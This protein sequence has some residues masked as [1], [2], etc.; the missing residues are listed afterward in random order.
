MNP[1][2]IFKRFF[3]SS[4]IRCVHYHGTEVAK[5]IP[6]H[7]VYKGTAFDL[8]D[9]AVDFVL[10]KISTEYI[11]RMGTGILDMIRRCVEADLPEPEFAVTD[12][13]VTTIRR[14]AIPGQVTQ[15]GM[16][17]AVSP[18]SRR[19]T[20]YGG[21]G[22]TRDQAGIQESQARG[23]GKGQAGRQKGED[24]GQSEGQEDQL[25]G[26][27]AWSEK[28]ID[29]LQACLDGAVSA[30]TLSAAVGYF[31]R[32]GHFRK[33]LKILIT[34]DFLEM[35]IPER[36]RS[37]AQKY[38]LTDKGRTAIASDG[39][40][41]A[42]GEVRDKKGEVGGEDKGQAEGQEGQL[43]GQAA[44]SEKETAMLRVC[45]DCTV[46]AEV[47]MAATGHSSR[48]GHFRRWLDRLLRDGLL[49]MTVPGKPRSP[50]QK[51]RLTSKGRSV[52]GRAAES[53]EGFGA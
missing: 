33:L 15:R 26:Q 10:G 7:Q 37:P 51:Y 8:V 11:E 35:T 53:S 41:Q 46:S 17:L 19:P 40:T 39:D 13:F 18:T 24:K 44:L 22:R 4:E 2:R 12:G 23:E 49:E 28:E 16:G 43:G 31:H 20:A 14:I 50:I 29:M 30:G 38:R 1:L 27:A 42:E 32:T 45:L 25:G 5:P 52:L 34:R 47:L 6:S 3:F 21:Y 48:T 9:R 36:P